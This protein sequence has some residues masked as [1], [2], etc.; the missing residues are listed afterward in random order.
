MMPIFHFIY[1]E[2]S[3][4]LLLR[5]GRRCRLADAGA[6][7]RIR[8]FRAHFTIS[9]TSAKISQC[10]R[11]ADAR[12]PAHL[13]RKSKRQSLG[14]QPVI[15]SRAQVQ[16]SARSLEGVDW[17]LMQLLRPLSAFYST[18]DRASLQRLDFRCI[19]PDSA[20]RSFR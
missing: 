8:I 6:M 5:H 19:R 18:F 13:L 1:Y 14:V 2:L 10:G 12:R 17:P 11:R 15:S 7:P 9:L 3:P 4:G 20:T 16:L